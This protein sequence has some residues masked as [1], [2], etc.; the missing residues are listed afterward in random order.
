MLK[1]PIQLI[2]QVVFTSGDSR[3]KEYSIRDA[4]WQDQNGLVLYLS[5]KGRNWIVI[6]SE[7]IPSPITDSNPFIRWI[8]QDRIVLVQRRSGRFERNIFV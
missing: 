8:D 3:F 1:T 7:W 4:D 5:I 6:N 2:E